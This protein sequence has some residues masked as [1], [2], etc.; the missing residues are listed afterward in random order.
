MIGHGLGAAGGLEA[1][2]CLG[3]IR[4]GWLHPTL[5]Q[6]DLE[7]SVKIDTCAAA[8]ARP[9][10]AAAASG[11]ALT[12]RARCCPRSSPHSPHSTPL[13]FRACQLRGRQGAPPGD[14]R[15]LQLVRVRGAQ[16]ARAAAASAGSEAESR[17]PHL[18]SPSPG[19]SVIVL[20]PYTEKV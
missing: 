17:G 16:Q 14:G 1:V 15:H 7:E 12:T 3:A 18:T 8:R 9:R 10:A 6:V 4:T 2:A 5:N 13:A 11:V 20:A 19:H